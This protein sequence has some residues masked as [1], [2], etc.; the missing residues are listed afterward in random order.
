MPNTTTVETATVTCAA[1]PRTTGS[2]AITAAAPQIALPAPISIAASRSILNTRMPSQQAS[3]KVLATTSTSISTP[4]TPTWP[5]S[6]KVRRRPYS[7]MP[8]RN[9]QCLEKPTPAALLGASRG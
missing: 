6:W 5:M 1:R 4:A 7:T 2:A 3:P 9:S 8:T